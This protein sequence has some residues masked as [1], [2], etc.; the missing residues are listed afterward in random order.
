MVDAARPTITICVFAWNEVA[1]LERV[2][3]EQLRVLEGLGQSHEVVLLDDGSTDGT[4]ELAD[5]LAAAHAAVRVIHH[6]SNRGLGP[7]YRTGFEEARGTYLSFFPADGQFPA[8]ILESFY[9]RVE[10]YDLILGYLPKRRGSPL[11]AALSRVERL[12]YRAMFG[13]M[14]RL[15]GV[16]M[17]RTSVLPGLRLKSQGRGWAIVMEL[18]IRAHRAGLRLVGVPTIMVPREVGVS[19]VNNWRHIQ[20]N[21]RQLVA[22]RRLLAEE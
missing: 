1:T 12:A 15:E 11:G 20:A 6:G 19:K 4:G 7:V 10:G 21:L 8:T 22:L 3:L 17:V 14:P 16:F 18:V 9:P 5:R 13:R 2:V